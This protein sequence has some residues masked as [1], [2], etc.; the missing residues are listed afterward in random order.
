VQN[1][2]AKSNLIRI[3]NL[4][5]KYTRSRTSLA[6]G[7]MRLNTPFFNPQD[8]RMNTT[9]EEGAWL[10]INEFK[11]VQING[12]WVWSISPRSTT[13]WFSKANSIGIYSSGV[14]EEG[15]KSNYYGNISSSV[16]TLGN[17]IINPGKS[18]KINLWDML[19][20]NVMNMS[21][22]ELNTEFGRNLTYYQGVMFIHQNAMNHGG[23]VDQTKTYITKGSQSNSISGQI[24][25]KTKRMNTSINYTHITADGRY[26]M[27]REWGRDPFYTFMS[28][29]RNDGFGKVHAVTTKTTVNFLKENLKTGLAYG[30]FLL[31]D[32][33]DYRLNKYGMPS[34]HQ[35]NLD[36]SYT[37][38]GFLKGLDIRFI[39]AYKLQQ[40]ET[41]HNL[42]YIYNKVN[43][44]NMSL[45]MDFKL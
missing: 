43:M 25:I 34:Y 5:L 3:E 33:K 17:M 27:P 8:G 9:I 13:Q 4:F 24:G 21:M 28:R 12:G 31:P 14:T 15:V 1:L 16:I 41:Y 42:K 38:T 2:S 10:T 23:N 36:I 19:V 39:A 18:I 20:D 32:V 7:K 30:Y 11:K 29:E 22:I 6:V 44:A 26:L 37:F 35:A 45:V 40:G